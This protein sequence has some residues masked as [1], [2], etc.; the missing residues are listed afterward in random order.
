MYIV[1]LLGAIVVCGAH[2]YGMQGA[3]ASIYGY[4]SLVH[5]LGGVAIGFCV[6]LCSRIFPRFTFTR[7]F[8][9]VI[10]GVIAIG[11]VWEIFEYIAD[12]AV[13]PGQS[14]WP[15]TMTDIVLDI[16]GGA[17]AWLISRKNV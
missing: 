7:K 14:Y 2:F 9:V 3:Y 12:I 4:D 13:L 6:V 10:L 11:V 1:A 17:G 8:W 16:I 15:D 5:F